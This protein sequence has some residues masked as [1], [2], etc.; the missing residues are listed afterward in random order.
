MHFPSHDPNTTATEPQPSDPAQAGPGLVEPDKVQPPEPGDLAP[1]WGI[2][3]LVYYALRRIL[4][5]VLLVAI[6]SVLV[7]VGTQVLPGDA[8]T[9]ILGRQ[10]TP[11]AIAAVRAELGLDRSLP[12]QYLDWLGGFVSGDL[13]ESFSAREPV[14]TYISTRAENSLTLALI[15]LAIMLPLSLWLGT[16][17]ALRQGRATDHAISGFTLAAIS[18]PEFVS[19]SLL[20]AFVAVSLGLLPP[21][22]LLDP[23]QPALAQPDLLVLPVAT[24]LLAGLA[25]NIRMV[26]AGVVG[27]MRSDYVRTARL[28][29]IPERR[30]IRRYGLR[31][32]LAPTVQVF[33]LTIQWLVGGVVIVEAVFQYPGLGQGLVQAVAARDIPVVQAVTMYIAILYVVINIIA[34]IVVVLLIPKLRTAR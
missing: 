32:A 7:F 28:N 3:P 26:R 2:H 25:Y 27:V 11:E 31:N 30:V 23:S 8:A 12:A 33:A 29:G 15:C 14:S 20:A 19:G 4:V 24:L 22:S 17:A 9:A 18:V 16:V 21:V 34:D 10:A 6:V 1:R 5:G 13:G